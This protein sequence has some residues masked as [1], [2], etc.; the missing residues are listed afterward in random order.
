[1]LLVIGHMGW[2]REQDRES[3]VVSTSLMIGALLATCPLAIATWYDRYH[4]KF[5]VV[6]EF[7]FLFT[8]VLLLAT[9]LVFQ[10]KSTTL[11]GGCTSALYFLTLLIL[12]PWS[13]LNSVAVAITVG[14]GT[15]FGF[16]LILAF[17]RDRLIVL[18][19]RIKQRQGVFRVLNWR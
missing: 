7:G 14:G 17:F 5:F 19:E 12:V 3:D 11:V 16:G 6:N 10:L 2:Y 8:S 1:M 18:P 9:G 13:Q 15:I 4:S